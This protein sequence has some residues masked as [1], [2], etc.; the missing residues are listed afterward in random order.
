MI[1]RLVNNYRGKTGILS[2]TFATREQLRDNL[3]YDFRCTE[4]E[5]RA[6]RQLGHY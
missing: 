3:R 4:T 6:E 1:S 5:L 2:M